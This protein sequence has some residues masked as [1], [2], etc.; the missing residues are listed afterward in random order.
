[1][2]S[3]FS[4][5][6]VV[7]VWSCS[8]Q[9]ASAGQASAGAAQMGEPSKSGLSHV[10]DRPLTATPTAAVTP[11]F[12]IEHRSALNGR[13]VKVKGKVTRWIA[14]KSSDPAPG[15]SVLPQPGA[16]PQPRVFLADSA[17]S[18]RDRTYDLVVLL[19]EGDQG[20]TIGDDV[21][22]EGVVDG[23]QQAVVVRRR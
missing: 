19:R 9:P 13:T 17:S 23:N 16:F 11:R 2:F 22:I 6:A 14:P 7:T 12:V 8:Q 10:P 21:E 1:M 20:F 18:D 5:L 15:D 3:T 4:V